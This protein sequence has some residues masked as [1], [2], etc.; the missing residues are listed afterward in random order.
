ME[1]KLT[2]NTDQ[3]NTVLRQLDQGPH[4]QVRAVIDYIIQQVNSQQPAANE[5]TKKPEDAPAA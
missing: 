5:D 1:F 3:I 2:L 4:A